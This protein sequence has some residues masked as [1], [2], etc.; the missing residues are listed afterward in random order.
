MLPYTMYLRKHATKLRWA[1]LALQGSVKEHGSF[2]PELCRVDAEEAGLPPGIS[3]YTSNTT[4]VCHGRRTVWVCKGCS[5][6]LHCE[7]PLRCGPP[8]WLQAEQSSCCAHKA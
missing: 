4:R 8:S 6:H 2:A 1:A 3:A 5:A 7:Q